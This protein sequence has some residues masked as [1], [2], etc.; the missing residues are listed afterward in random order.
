[1]DPR[2]LKPTLETSAVSGL[3]LAGQINGTTGYEEA[4]AQGIIAG[5]NA[6]LAAVG[7]DPLVLH[8]T[9]SFIGVLIDDLTSLGA[10][11]PYRMFTSR[12]EYRLSL[13]AE[14]ADLRLT[15]RGRDAGIVGDDRYER[16]VQRRDRVEQGINT[17]HSF[18]LSSTEWNG[19]GVK[20]AQDGQYKS[21][22]DLL[23]HPGVTLDDMRSVMA[24]HGHACDIHPSV[25][26]NVY[27]QMRYAGYLRRQQR[28]IDAFK[29][30][31][32]MPLPTDINYRET[33][34]MVSNEEAEL[35][36]AARPTTIHAAGRIPGIRPS[37]LMCLFQ[38]AKNL[39]R[40]RRPQH[41]R[42]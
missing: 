24:D 27:V 1:M 23:A 33:L 9:D 12:S 41:R 3:F 10:S 14:N 28:A 7:K 37:T 36:A 32:A 11:E 2:V 8:R 22:G 25:E 26:E 29:Q 16:F 30:G 35:L 19:A 6:G 21:A 17:L 40:G 38:F 31:H 5:A 15:Q 18:K 39:Q 34:P 13:R 42:Q 4:G 20:V